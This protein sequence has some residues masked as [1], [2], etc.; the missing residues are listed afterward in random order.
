MKRLRQFELEN[1][2]LKM[3]VVKRVL[4][5]EVMKEIAVKMVSI[6]VR[7]KL[8]SL[9]QDAGFGMNGL[10]RLG[11]LQEILQIRR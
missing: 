11:R 3:F 6:P 9:R 4:E 2:R 10:T 5:I 1:V 7:R 8:G